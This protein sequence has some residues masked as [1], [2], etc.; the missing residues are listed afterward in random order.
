MNTKKEIQNILTDYFLWSKSNNLAT[1]QILMSIQSFMNLSFIP[2]TK[3]IKDQTVNDE[4]ISTLLS[5]TVEFSS[6]RK[7]KGAYYT[8]NDVVNYTVYNLIYNYLTDRHRV[9]SVNE[10]KKET[11]DSSKVMEVCTEKTFLDPT[12]GAGEFA[13]SV[14]QAKIFFLKSIGQDSKRNIIAA[15]S[16]IYGNDIDENATLVSK[17]RILFYLYHSKVIEITDNI[18][19]IVN[20]N[21][22]NYDFIFDSMPTNKEYD[23]IIGNPPYI[24]YRTM[25]KKPETNYGNVYADVLHNT[26]F[27]LHKGGGIAYVIPISFSSTLR[28]KSI[29]EEE[30]S[31]FSKLIVLHFADRPDSLFRSVHQKVDIVFGLGFREKG[32]SI[33]TSSYNYW[34]KDERSKLFD[35]LSVIKND[36][37]DGGLLPKYGNTIQKHIY[38]K[39]TNFYNRQLSDFIIKDNNSTY[40]G[41]YLAKRAS[42]Y[43]KSFLKN[44]KSNEYD[45][46]VVIQI[47]S[48]ALLAILNSTLFWMYW[49]IISDGWHLTNKELDN[50]TI[51]LLDEKIDDKL[52]VL[53]DKLLE[54]LEQTKVYVGTVQTDYE[55]KHK[56]ALD[57]ID[58]IDDVLG[59]V[60]GLDSQ[61]IKYIKGYE[62][63]YRGGE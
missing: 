39:I 22:S 53:T 41:I 8:P 17:L 23:F 35:G 46:Y 28:M 30:V 15:L 16:T 38:Q 54:R 52:T 61:E 42:F 50:F 36:N 3:F 25:K 12:C 14:L 51:P 2:D 47:S 7:Q 34:Y 32:N 27:H 57:I 6:G 49:V 40:E 11:Y 24:E 37:Y 43:I 13:L 62:R 59:S 44:P 26:N 21:F 33:Y 1:S 48:K 19:N 58:E 56:N 9:L 4:N 55:Y 63:K 29:R 31:S 60:Y 5:K 20:S 18:T 10:I 45:H